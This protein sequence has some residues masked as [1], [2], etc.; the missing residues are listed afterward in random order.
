VTLQN[1][2][3]LL[4]YLVAGGLFNQTGDDTFQ[5]KWVRSRDRSRRYRLGAQ[6]TRAGNGIDIADVQWQW[7]QLDTP[8]ETRRKEP[9]PGAIHA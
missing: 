4:R 6:I 8:E 9:R 1:E 7:Q 5:G 2:I 3:R